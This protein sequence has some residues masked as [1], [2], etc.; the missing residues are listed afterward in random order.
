MYK[1]IRTTDFSKV[2][3]SLYNAKLLGE[4]PCE[5]LKP[6]MLYIEG[7]KN[8]ITDPDCGVTDTDLHNMAL[9][10][11]ANGDIDCRE[12]SKYINAMYKACEFLP[13]LTFTDLEKL[14]KSIDDVGQHLKRCGDSYG[15]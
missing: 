5:N 6:L 8:K 13:Q 14:D 7:K 12:Y 1:I 11:M 4:F 10:C 15:C 3:K 9:L 2:M